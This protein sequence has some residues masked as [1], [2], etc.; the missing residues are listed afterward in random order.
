MSVAVQNPSSPSSSSILLAASEGS[1]VNKRCLSCRLQ[2]PANYMGANASFAEI[3]GLFRLVC[4][5]IHSLPMTVFYSRGPRWR[6]AGEQLVF[7]A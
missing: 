7:P 6:A 1:D 4:A 2:S 5:E 3:P